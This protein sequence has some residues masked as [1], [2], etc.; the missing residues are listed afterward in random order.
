[1][2]Y[3]IVFP[4]GRKVGELSRR[5]VLLCMP[6]MPAGTYIDPPIPSGNEA[7]RVFLDWLCEK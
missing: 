7:A 4:D 2:K 1:M 5:E 6:Y 3:T